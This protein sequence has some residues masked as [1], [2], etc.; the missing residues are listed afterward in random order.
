MPVD[1]SMFVVITVFVSGRQSELHLA[2]NQ[3]VR[4]GFKLV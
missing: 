2:T 4:F 1:D 3:M